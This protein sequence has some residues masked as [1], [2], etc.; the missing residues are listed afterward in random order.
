[1][2][3]ASHLD[4]D[5]RQED[6]GLQVVLQRL[7]QGH[8]PGAHGR[9]ADRMTISEEQLLPDLHDPTLVGQC[10]GGGRTDARCAASRGMA[11]CW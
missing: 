1:M 5:M 7:A 11:A 6:G 4:P 9:Q 10:Q 2:S 3:S 8:Q